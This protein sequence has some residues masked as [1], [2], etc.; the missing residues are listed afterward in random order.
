MVHILLIQPGEVLK[1]HFQVSED[2]GSVPVGPVEFH[3]D[4]RA[5]CRLVNPDRILLTRLQ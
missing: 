5:H 1:E 2:D 3:I 4:F